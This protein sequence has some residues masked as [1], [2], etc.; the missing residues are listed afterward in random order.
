M[1]C[2][3]MRLLSSTVMSGVNGGTGMPAKQHNSVSCSA[4]MQ[5]VLGYRHE[6]VWVV[7]ILDRF[8]RARVDRSLGVFC[9]EQ[10]QRDE[11]IAQDLAGVNIKGIEFV[12]DNGSAMDSEAFREYCRHPDR[13][14]KLRY[15]SAHHQHQN[16]CEH[17]WARL[18][19]LSTISLSQAPH[20]GYEYW[21]RAMLHANH[22]I[23]YWPSS[24]N[25]GQRSP[26]EAWAMGMDSDTPS[27]YQLPTHL[28]EFG[29]VQTTGRWHE[30]CHR[31]SGHAH[32]LGSLGERIPRVGAHHVP[33]RN[34]AP[35][36]IIELR[37][38]QNDHGPCGTQVILH[39]QR[40]PT[41][42]SRR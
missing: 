8:E 1:V 23:Q 28:V 36:Q 15:S 29:R 4:R 10:L 3:M 5:G 12:T 37:R 30:R 14:W 18:N 16:P 2:P 42:G 13:Q 24:A 22:S 19:G 7:G 31:I 35:C 25:A 40:V 11:L 38:M 20:V 34:R 21:D 39:A 9:C 26:M 41:C 27:C 17:L 33:W 32:R 6:R